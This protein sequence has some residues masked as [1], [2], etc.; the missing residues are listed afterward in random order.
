MVFSSPAFILLF[1]PLVLLTA[2]WG[3]ERWRNL[4]LIVWSLWFYYYGGG[5]MVVLLVVSC[6]VN[7][8][9][10]LAVELRRSR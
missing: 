9:L 4:V 8:A 5:G 6:L 10:G 1:L 2:V 3:A 7:W